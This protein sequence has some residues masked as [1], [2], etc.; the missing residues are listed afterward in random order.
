MN[1]QDE[2]N[3]HVK[4][5]Q[6]IL[7][8]ARA[9]GR[10]LTADEQTAFDQHASEAENLKTVLAKATEN[11][12]RIDALFKTGDITAGE[13]DNDAEDAPGRDLGQRFTAGKAYEQWHK[14]ADTFGVGGDIRI[15]KT[16]VGSLAEYYQ[17][18]AGNAIG[19]QIGQPQN[20]RMPAVDLVNRPAVT[21]L[22]YISRGTTSGDFEYLQI[23]SVTRNTGIVPENTGDDATDT[24]KPQ[25]TFATNLETAKVYQYADGYTVT[26]QLL[27][28]DQAMASFLQSEFDYS[29]GLKLADTL[30]NGSG[31]NGQ[32]KGLLNTTGV[33]A[34]EWAKADDEARN[35]V[36]AIRKSL[37][38]LR[39]VGASANAILINPEDAEKIDLMQ[40]VNKRFMGN[41]PFSVG[42]TTVWSRPLV[43]CDQIEPGKIIV[44]DFKQL[45]LL[46]RSGLSVEAFNQHKDYA[47][48][49]LTYVRAELRAAQVV[50]RPAFFVV[51]EGK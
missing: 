1:I 22:D 19:T 37:T 50:W 12:R 33:Q 14:N 8:K 29:F 45:A 42:P 7:A 31:T 5:A 46:D 39:N 41:G 9:E 20:V 28:D 3:K 35:I 6:D 4:M 16:P 25:S 34:G 40:D 21:L 32:P 38:K 24:I 49:N 17:S 43:E 26:N 15:A 10:D 13:A 44:G 51:L 36:I 47:A 23:T 2:I 48:R 18:K 11:T 27:Q 30:L